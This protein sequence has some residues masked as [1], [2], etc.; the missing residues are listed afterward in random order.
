[1]SQ[2][3]SPTEAYFLIDAD[4][5]KTFT[6]LKEKCAELEKQLAEAL[7]YKRLASSVH[8]THLETKIG[9]L[10][11]QLKKHKSQTVTTET[12][13]PSVDGAKEQIGSGLQPDLHSESVQ[14]NVANNLSN[15]LFTND[16]DFRKQLTTAFELFLKT[17]NSGHT[18]LLNVAENQA[19]SGIT[20]DVTP[21][22][23]LQLAEPAGS[24]G[25]ITLSEDPQEKNELQA[26]TLD[27]QLLSSVPSASRPK[28]QKLL[29]ELKH[30]NSDISFDASGT[31]HLNGKI[32]PDSNFYEIF[33]LLF[34]RPKQYSSN[35]NLTLVVNELVSLG[36]GHLIQRFYTA[37]LTPRGKQYLKN[38]AATK[39]T[40]KDHWYYL[41]NDV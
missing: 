8:Q 38:R 14:N 36:L 4:E 22:L 16:D 18:S 21:T 13:E 1:M 6:E 17:Q 3:R 15:S 33:P 20:D 32:L 29:A 25:Q 5:Y 41:G 40:L 31:V 35:N 19:G 39:A 23:P 12:L 34:K 24:N 28:A 7:K 30:F 27:D 9:D 26:E 10:E 37:G 11:A 2:K